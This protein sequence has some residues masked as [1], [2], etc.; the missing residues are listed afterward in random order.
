[1]T[2]IDPNSFRVFSLAVVVPPTA[3]KQHKSNPKA[4]LLRLGSRLSYTK[5]A[6]AQ[7]VALK[8]KKPPT[9]PPTS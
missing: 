2:I 3:I 8:V 9:T 1:M 4:T 7:Q 5:L 6:N